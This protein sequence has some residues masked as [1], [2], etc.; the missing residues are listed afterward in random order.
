MAIEDDSGRGDAVLKL[1]KVT[2]MEAQNAVRVWGLL[3]ANVTISN[4]Y[5]QQ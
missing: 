2:E 1:E 5:L 3:P 4:S